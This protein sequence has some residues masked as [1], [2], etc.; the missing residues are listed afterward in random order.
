MSFAACI[1]IALYVQ[2]EFSYDKHWRDSD[3][4]YRVNWITMRAGR[5]PQKYPVSSMLLLPVL[6]Q[7]FPNDIEL[8]AR[9]LQSSAPGQELV[10]GN[11][12]FSQ[13][14]SY[15]EKDVIE[16]FQFQ[17]LEGDLETVFE[18]TNSIALNE[19]SALQY[20]GVESPIGQIISATDIA[21]GLQEYRV[22]AVYRLA[23]GNTVLNLPNMVLYDEEK[24]SRWG[25]LWSSWILVSTQNYIR[26]N[27]ETDLEF[28]NANMVELLD[29]RVNLPPERLEFGQKPSDVV[30]VE[31][32][33][34]LD[35]YFDPIPFQ[36]YD[37]VSGNRATALLFMSISVLVA[38]VG[39]VNFIVLTTA[40]ATQ[41]ELEIALKK[42]LGVR[43]G[44]L[45]VQF[46]GESFLVVFAAI[47]LALLGVELLMPFYEGVVGENLGLP[48][49]SSSLYLYLLV[50][51]IG[52]GFLGG[53]YP[54]VM[55]SKLSSSRIF[56][57]GRSRVL[58]NTMSFRGFLVIFQF[59]VAI[60]LIMATAT[61]YWQLSYLNKIDPGFNPSELLV[62]DGFAQAEVSPHREVIKQEVLNLTEVESASYSSAKP[63]S[64]LGF[65]YDYRVQGESSNSMETAISTLFIDHD[66]FKTFQ[67]PLSAGRYPEPGRDPQLPFRL[68]PVP[69][70]R[71]N[72]QPASILINDAAARQFGFGS[73]DDALGRIIEHGEPGTQSY[74]EFL[75]VGV[76][77]DSQFQSVRSIPEPQVYYLD[78]SSTYNLTIR[79]QGNSQKFLA[80]VEQIWNSVVGD[81]LLITGFVQQEISEEYLREQ[82]E[83][84]LLV[85]FSMLSIFIAC[86]GLYGMA[87]FSLER[88]TTEMGLR[89]VLG[90]Q[91]EDIVTLL[92]LQFSKPVIFANIIA[93]P[94]AMWSI[95]NWLERFPYQ[96][97]RWMLIPLG[98]TAGLIAMG[99]VFF[100]ITMK[101]VSVARASPGESLRSE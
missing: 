77:A 33:K 92:L 85:Y 48:Y 31:F 9:L 39:C 101:G 72:Q 37:S 96:F 49:S 75:I 26:L 66:F 80:E 24:I 89:K 32:Q 50:L 5:V 87:T 67:I 64:G 69:E 88:R 65:M 14:L 78:L 54:A 6:K 19:D 62:V 28:L 15:T 25:T 1:L 90:A 98:L 71:Q 97:D 35:I 82:N 22:V 21:G 44:R 46:M 3:R 55:Y 83:G 95:L 73:S 36:N 51:I 79:F 20:F 4:I 40:R 86:I 16:L 59:A 91:M 68:F 7:Y 47:I 76:A 100:T 99:V 93:W 94:I 74:Q 56:R 53:V 41:R 70:E 11:T 30:A 52:F 2:N 61:V 60:V 27:A 34:M 81:R 10:I 12:H 63:N 58:G 13:A 57:G 18:D 23:P 38:L 84:K 29:S 45:V 42:M 8:G 43:P 17:V